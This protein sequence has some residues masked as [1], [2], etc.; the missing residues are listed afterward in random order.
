VGVAAITGGVV[1]VRV[2]VTVGGRGVAVTALVD[3]NAGSV[4]GGVMVAFASVPVEVGV[5]VS[6]REYGGT[7]VRV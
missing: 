5:W 1:A 2:G 7:G 4:V 6:V 3:V